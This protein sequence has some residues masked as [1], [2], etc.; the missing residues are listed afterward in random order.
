M[1]YPITRYRDIGFF[2]DLKM[3]LFE[4]ETELKHRIRSITKKIRMDVELLG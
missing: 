3:K 2:G 4:T 1:I